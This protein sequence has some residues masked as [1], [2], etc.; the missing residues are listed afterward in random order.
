M[1]IV[2]SDEGYDKHLVDPRYHSLP[3]LPTEPMTAKDMTKKYNHGGIVP[4]DTKKIIFAC[5]AVKMKDGRIEHRPH[6]YVIKND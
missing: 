6:M 2:Y 3:P 1:K 4:G 5:E